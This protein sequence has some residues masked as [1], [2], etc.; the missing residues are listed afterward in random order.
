MEAVEAAESPCNGDDNAKALVILDG[1][2][3]D[4]ESLVCVR[5]NMRDGKRLLKWNTPR[6]TGIP[7]MKGLA[8]NSA[9]MI[10]IAEKWCPHFKSPR[11]IPIGPIRKEL[12]DLYELHN[13]SDE[14]IGI[15][16]DAT[17][18]KRIFSTGIRRMGEAMKNGNRDTC[19]H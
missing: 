11:A 9:V 10:T 6:E 8:M 13:C 15:Q 12:A 16:V 1:L 7:S 3:K 5:D 4:L 14:L 18:I 2:A 17:G 19:T